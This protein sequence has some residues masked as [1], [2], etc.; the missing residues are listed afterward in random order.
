MSSNNFNPVADF[1]SVIVPTKDRLSYLKETLASVQAQRHQNWEA[2]VVDDGS[3]DGTPDFLRSAATTDPRIRPVARAEHRAIGGA[4]V[5][6]NV[7]LSQARGTFALFLDSDDLLGPECLSRRLECLHAQPELKFVVGQCQLFNH[8]ANDCAERWADWPAGQD[9]LDAFVG[10]GR[11]PWQT[12]GPLW[13]RSFLNAVG[14]WDEELVH[15]GH[16]HEFHVRA[17]C[18]G[19][20]HTKIDGVDYYWRRP[21]PDSL[22]SQEAFQRRHAAG[23]MIL[24]FRKML[25]VVDSTGRMTPARRLALRREAIRLAT[26]CRLNQGAFTTARAAISTAGEARLLSLH[27][28][29]EI[30]LALRLWPLRLGSKIPSMAYLNRRF[31]L[32]P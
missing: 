2:L 21:R 32:N 13:R 15:A 25:A 29:I 7:G 30:G 18:L 12:S 19:A 22:S 24:A 23:D 6:R 10:L 17:L 31:G 28:R 14:P 4:Q 26:L 3:T 9:D 8:T 16:D 11:I 1:V 27:E 20:A 5:C